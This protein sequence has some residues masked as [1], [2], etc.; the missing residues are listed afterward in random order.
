MAPLVLREIL[1]VFDNTLTDDS[2]YPVQYRKYLQLRTQMIL[3]EKLTTFFQIFVPFLESLS[4]FK[5]FEKKDN[6]HS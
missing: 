5:G 1:G 6:R 2:K 3:S 4:N